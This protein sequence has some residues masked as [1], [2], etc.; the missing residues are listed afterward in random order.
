M[1]LT[2]TL[3]SALWETLGNIGSLTTKDCRGSSA[4]RLLRRLLRDLGEP[5]GATGSTSGFGFGSFADAGDSTVGIEVC[6]LHQ[7]TI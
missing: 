7:E 3:V 4:G 5:V 6:E 2:C 1:V